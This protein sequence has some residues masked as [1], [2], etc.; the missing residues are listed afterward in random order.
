MWRSG[1][2]KSLRGLGD[3]D[4]PLQGLCERTVGDI[5]VHTEAIE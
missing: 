1:F 5:R 3:R 4:R 2:A